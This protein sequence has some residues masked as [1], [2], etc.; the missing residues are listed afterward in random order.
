[1]TRA[2]CRLPALGLALLLGW[3][4]ACRHSPAAHTPR[5]L[6]GP[7][8]PTPAYYDAGGTVPRALSDTLVRTGPQATYRRIELPPRVPATLAATPRSGDPIEL[9]WIEPRPSSSVPRPLILISPILSNKLTLM[10]EF[11]T[12]FV[13]QGYSAAI[14]PRKE[15]AF[16]P[17]RSLVEA[18]AESRLVIMRARQ[19]LDWL[20]QQPQVDPQRIGFFGVSAGGIVG[21]SLLGADPRIRAG[22]LVFAGAPMADVFVGTSED[23]IRSSIERTERERGWS[24]A[25]IRQMLLQNLRTDPIVLA[26][27]VRRES[28][29]LFLATKDDSVPSATQVRL[30]NALGR[31]EAHHLSVGHYTG[32]GLFLPFIAHESQRFLAGRLGAPAR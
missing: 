10:N 1:M 9:L 3:A 29:L 5:C 11:A 25:Q 26:P 30:W 2:E 15:L 22:V 12:G 24:K 20:L 23:R 31:P 6:P 18:E 28:V 27:R 13:R 8:T 14:L 7:T 17:Q 16:D 19:A 21:A 32:V 4:S